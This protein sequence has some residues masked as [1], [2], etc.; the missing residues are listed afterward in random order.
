M[1]A[2]PQKNPWPVVNPG[3]GV[4]SSFFGRHFFFFCFFDQHSPDFLQSG[5]WLGARAGADLRDLGLTEWGLA[6]RALTF[7]ALV[8]EWATPLPGT[9]LQEW[10]ALA[11]VREWGVV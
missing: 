9:P 2:P 10:E 3:G 1:T 7:V 4:S 5:G 11:R 6:W 8:S